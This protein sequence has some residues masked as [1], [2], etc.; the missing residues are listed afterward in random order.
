MRRVANV[1]PLPDMDVTTEDVM[2]IR[3]ACDRELKRMGK[4]AEGFQFGFTNISRR[5]RANIDLERWLD[6][7]YLRHV[8]RS[9]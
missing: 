3:R 2:Q 7:Q 6:A 4:S 5:Q 8:E 1:A 9:A